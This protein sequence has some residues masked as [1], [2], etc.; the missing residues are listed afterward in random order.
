MQFTVE[1]NSDT[2]AAALRQASQD[3]AD[4]TPLM[5]A[6][7]KRLETNISKRF[8]T[9]T[10]PAG[11]AWEPYKAI[12]AAIHKARTGKDIT[13]SL[14]ERTGIMRGGIEHHA[15]AD[16]VEVGLTAPYAVFH[17]FGTGGRMAPMGGGP[18]KPG[19]KGIGPIPRR[20]MVFGAVSGQGQG[21]QVTQ[22]LSA[23]DEADIIAIIQ[24]HIQQATDGLA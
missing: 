22:A 18:F 14:L 17:E 7:G 9:K 3:I 13:G 1:S 15:S 5:A 20:G 21:A 2:I 16:Q 4:T 23:G 11:K 10:D 24:R 8:D 12:S 6:I 19:T